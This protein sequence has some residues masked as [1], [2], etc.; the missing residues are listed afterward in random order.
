MPKKKVKYT[1]ESLREE[2]LKH[3][4]RGDFKKMAPRHYQAASAMG[5]IPD[6][7]GHMPTSKNAPYSIEELRS[8]AS[9]YTTTLEFRANSPKQY[10]VAYKKGLLV[11]IF[12]HRVDNPK[13]SHPNFSWTPELIAQEA[14]KYNTKL[15]FMENCGGAYQAAYR[16][17]VLDNI[18][19]HMKPN[20]GKKEIWTKEAIVR[21]SLKFE[22]LGHFRSQSGAAYVAAFR[23]GINE[24]IFARFVRLSG[25]SGMERDLFGIIKSKYPKAHTF[26]DRKVVI[27]GKPHITGFDIDIYVPELRKGVEFDGTYWH[28][29]EGLARSKN[30]KLWPKADLEQYHAIKDGYFKNKGIAIYH[31][32]EADW[33]QNN[34]LCVSNI[35]N[36]LEENG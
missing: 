35:I 30:R 27:E 6:I 33:V 22:T 12:S 1:P 26:R 32:R 15:E 24:E 16:N 4:T 29:Q 19:A 9:K 11:D 18:C 8:E 5:L 28:S 10:E 23:K 31:V 3:S 17:G 36:F 21:E 13:E 34:E 25:S 7:T 2:A 20:R 14:L